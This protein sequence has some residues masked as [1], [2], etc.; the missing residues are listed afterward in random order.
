MN[1]GYECPYCGSRDIY[2]D[3]VDVGPGM[4]KCGPA[5]CEDCQSFEL[6]Y[7]IDGVD[8]TALGRMVTKLELK[9]GWFQSEKAQLLTRLDYP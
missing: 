5:Q 9:T 6:P 4:M 3:E 1:S 2:Y 7:D 8:W